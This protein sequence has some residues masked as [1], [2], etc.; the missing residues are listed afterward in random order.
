MIEGTALGGTP[1]HIIRGDGSVAGGAAGGVVGAEMIEGTAF[2]ERQGGVI[3]RSGR[4]T[5]SCAAC[6]VV[7]AK[8]IDR[9]ALGEQP[10][11]EIN[12]SCGVAGGTAGGVVV[13]EE[14]SV[15]ALAAGQLLP[16]L[17]EK[18]GG[19]RDVTEWSQLTAT[20]HRKTSG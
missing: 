1:G 17:L 10:S 11:G 6:G 12:R 4:S 18:T 16:L 20:C 3:H 19:A 9:T 2:V 13:A 14:G 7:V 8:V 5:A 15:A